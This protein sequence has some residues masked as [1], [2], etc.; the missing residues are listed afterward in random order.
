MKLVTVATIVVFILVNCKEAPESKKIV[1]TNTALQEA[2]LIDT[3]QLMKNELVTYLDYS[4]RFRIDEVFHKV[5]SI[6]RKL[7]DSSNVWYSHFSPSQKW[8]VKN[9]SSVD[10][11]IVYRWNKSSIVSSLSV[12]GQGWKPLNVLWINDSTILA[13]IEFEEN[14]LTNEK[15]PKYFEI[16]IR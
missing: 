6:K 2:I 4:F 11:F 10:G 15:N 13:K 7:D 3:V 14:R 9:D 16:G 12:Q 1:S 8:I 5:D